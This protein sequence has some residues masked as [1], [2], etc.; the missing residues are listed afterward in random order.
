[1]ALWVAGWVYLERA[2]LQAELALLWL[3]LQHPLT[4]DQWCA[5]FQRASAIHGQLLSSSVHG[6]WPTP[7][8]L[9]QRVARY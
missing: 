8:D 3:R 5:V 2:A 7:L 6:D 9:L 4:T 1:M